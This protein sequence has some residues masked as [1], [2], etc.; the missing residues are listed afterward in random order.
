MSTIEKIKEENGMKSSEMVDL[1]TTKN[2]EKNENIL[3]KSIEM[4]TDRLL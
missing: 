2:L 1:D 3:E 4:E